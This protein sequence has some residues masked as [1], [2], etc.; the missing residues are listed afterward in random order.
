MGKLV[1][2]RPARIS[3]NTYN[4][5]SKEGSWPKVSG[6][7]NLMTT[8]SFGVKPELKANKS[9]NCDSVQRHVSSSDQI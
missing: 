1:A 7:P 2:G 4:Y 9:M 8:V 5:K 6:C 3:K